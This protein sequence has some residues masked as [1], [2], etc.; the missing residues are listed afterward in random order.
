MS[1]CGEG[2]MTDAPDPNE[3]SLAGTPSQMG[4][5]GPCGSERGS[6]FG[7]EGRTKTE[8]DGGGSRRGLPASGSAQ[9]CLPDILDIQRSLAA[10]TK[11]RGRRSALQV[12][13]L[14]EHSD[15]KEPSRKMT[16]TEALQK[17]RQAKENKAS[18][19][20]ATSSAVALQSEAIVPLSAASPISH[21]SV[22]FDAMT[23][24][25][26]S[27][28]PNSAF[29]ASPLTSWMAEH[30]HTHSRHRGRGPELGE[31]R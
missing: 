10:R 9:T 11:M 22:V 18:A 21:K 19:S 30:T 2:A 16:R 4:P 24:E 29:G 8:D 26:I 17:A 20:I 28:G 23:M 31:N 6:V 3:S 7:G 14:Q 12:E 27:A 5:G 1:D 25:R 13:I 15:N